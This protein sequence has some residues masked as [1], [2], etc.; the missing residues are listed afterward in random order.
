MPWAVHYS[1]YPHSLKSTLFTNKSTSNAPL[2]IS[3]EYSVENVEVYRS[4]MAASGL[5]RRYGAQVGLE[6][7]I[8][9]LRISD[10]LTAAM[11]S[12][13]E[14]ERHCDP[15]TH[16][17]GS[18][19]PFWSPTLP[20]LSHWSHRTWVREMYNGCAARSPLQLSPLP[21]D[22]NYWFAV[23]FLVGWFL[24]A[25]RSISPSWTLNIFHDAWHHRR[26]PE[27]ACRREC[28]ALVA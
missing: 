26:G 15:S 17:S 27:W 6:P 23:W 20:F 12:T 14:G 4:P 3:S 19:F 9:Q 21:T 11:G 10:S 8:P 1:P 16:C 22:S 28:N 24:K 2:P 13:P 5:H 18:L 25:P 7:Q